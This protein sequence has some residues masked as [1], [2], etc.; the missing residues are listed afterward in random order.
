MIGRQVCLFIDTV[1]QIDPVHEV[2]EVQ[3]CP[4]WRANV[5]Q[6]CDVSIKSVRQVCDR[7]DLTSSLDSQSSIHSKEL[8]FH[9]AQD[10]LRCV[11][12][13]VARHAHLEHGCLA[14]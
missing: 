4:R 1:L 5:R 6:V 12:A 13:A 2:C 10:S 8:T 9:F 11:G 3:E 7:T 14:L